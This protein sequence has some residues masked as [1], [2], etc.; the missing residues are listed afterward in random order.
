MMA[1]TQ[2]WNDN[3]LGLLTKKDRKLGAHLVMNNGFAYI[4]H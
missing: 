3:E 1:T 2:D 4:W